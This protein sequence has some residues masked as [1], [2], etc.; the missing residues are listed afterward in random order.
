MDKEIGDHRRENGRQ[1][2]SGQPPKRFRS[3]AAAIG[4]VILMVTLV[5]SI[6]LPVE[7]SG[8]DSYG[9]R[10]PLSPNVPDVSALL[11]R[12]RN[13]ATTDGTSLAN[14]VGYLYFYD[15]GFM[16]VELASLDVG[17]NTV[18]LTSE[19]ASIGLQYARSNIDS[20]IMVYNIALSLPG[21]GSVDCVFV[22]NGIS[23]Q[24]QN[25]FSCKS[26]VALTCSVLTEVMPGSKYHYQRPT[27][28][29]VLES[30]E[31]E[32]FGSEDSIRRLIFDKPPQRNS[33]TQFN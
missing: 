3:T 20:K 2:G 15:Q 14:M 8:G 12:I 26:R 32:L 28:E 11:A 9:H 22:P 7:S 29:L 33:C 17:N 4:A 6:V 10:C 31:L 21:E 1:P 16:P 27:A 5:R 24:I 23:C 13:I 19:C 30:F 18:T 25:R